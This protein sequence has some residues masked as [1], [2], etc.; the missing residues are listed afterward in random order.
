M[1]LDGGEMRELSPAAMH[2]SNMSSWFTPPVI[3]PFLMTLLAAIA[4]LYRVYG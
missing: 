3:V 1:G 2:E 4:T